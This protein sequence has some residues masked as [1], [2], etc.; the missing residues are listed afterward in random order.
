MDSRFVIGASLFAHPALAGGGFTAIAENINNLIS[1]NGFGSYTGG[2]GIFVRN[3]FDDLETGPEQVVPATFWSNDLAAPSAFYPGSGGG[4]GNPWCPNDGNDG[5]FD[6]SWSCD[7]DIEPNTGE[8]HPWNFAQLGY[9]IGSGMTA[10]LADW[11]NVQD[12]DWGWGIFYPTDSNSVDKRCRWLG[13]EGIYDCPGGYVDTNG[14]FQKDSSYGGTGAYPAGNPYVD[15]GYLNGGGSGCHFDTSS[16]RIDQVDAYDSSGRNLVKNADCEC[17][18]DLRGNGWGDWVD[19]W[20]ENFQAKPGLPSM[21]GSTGL[22]APSWGLDISACWVSNLRD[23]IQ[24]QNQIYWSRDRWSNQKVPKSEWSQDPASLRRYWGWN[25]MP[26]NK[27]RITNANNW[28][29]IMIKLPADIG[30]RADASDSVWDLSQGA[31]MRMAKDIEQWADAG[32][33]VPGLDNLSNRPGS[34]VLFVKEFADDNYNWETMFYCEDWSESFSKIK[35][36]FKE[37]SGGDGGACYAEWAGV[38]VQV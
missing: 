5:L 7:N 31:R 27:A 22:K 37:D 16:G 29:A 4:F 1:S 28:D 24:L 23:A 32:Y 21:L 2:P 9:V 18:D 30:G 17:N 34:Y 14:N 26:M 25:E 15:T 19:N 8:N 36:V 11:D 20:I 6:L 3:P 13:S 38:G 35:I 10:L 33:L 12:D